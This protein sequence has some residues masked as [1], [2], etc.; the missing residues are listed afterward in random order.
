MSGTKQKNS[1]HIFQVQN[2]DTMVSGT[3]HT[4]G[5]LARHRGTSISV[6]TLLLVT[7][8][9]DTRITTTNHPCG[10]DNKVA[11]KLWSGPV[12]HSSNDTVGI[13]VFGC[14][15]RKHSNG[16]KVGTGLGPT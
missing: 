3:E 14:E 6:F 4:T 8:W 5:K 9:R 13:T 16:N 10:R 7:W 11:G 12:K 2:R 15:K 1:S